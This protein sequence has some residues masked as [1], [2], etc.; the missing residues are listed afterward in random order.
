MCSYYNIH[1]HR[2]CVQIFIEIPFQLFQSIF[3][4]SLVPNFHA[5]ALPQ[6]PQ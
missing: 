6:A 2:D 5:N 4:S 3:I 1:D